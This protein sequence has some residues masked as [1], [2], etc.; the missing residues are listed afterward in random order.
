MKII[1]E[2]TREA[3]VR[4]VEREISSILRKLAKQTVI[5]LQADGVELKKLP[6][7][8]FDERKVE[9]FLGIPKFKEKG[10]DLEPKIGSVLGL[11]WTS[12]GGEILNVEATI[13]PGNEKLILTGKLGD[14]MKESAQAALSYIR[15]NPGLMGVSEDF[16]KNKDIHIHLPEGAIP[17]DGPSAGITMAMAIVSAASKR[18][19]RNDVA[20]TG[21]IT[22]RGNLLAVGGLNEKLLAAQRS[23]IKIVLIPSDNK[24]DLIE[25][26][27]KVKKG[28]KI[29][30][31][32]KTEEAI[33]FLFKNALKNKY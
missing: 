4:N 22:L 10:K 28:L 15:S 17:K 21:E 19:A 27:N 5:K 23:G 32:K 6:E 1:R 30:P 26:P 20:M 3:G 18:S 11:A 16:Y 14:V 29:I 33:P 12:L 25:I 31:I 9:E 7:I 13:M 24:K 2:Y 8:R